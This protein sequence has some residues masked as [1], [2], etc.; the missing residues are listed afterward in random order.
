[1]LLGTIGCDSGSRPQKTELSAKVKLLKSTIDELESAQ[2]ELRSAYKI[3]HEEGALDADDFKKK[4]GKLEEYRYLLQTYQKSLSR[5]KSFTNQDSWTER[6]A[7]N[8]ID[9]LD[10]DIELAS[11]NIKSITAATESLNN[12]SSGSQ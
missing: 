4:Q 6:Q 12:D 3:A 1:M 7:K 8:A 11:K 9:R 2:A 10:L 5:G